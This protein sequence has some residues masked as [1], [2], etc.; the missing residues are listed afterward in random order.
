M[1][2]GGQIVPAGTVDGNV[3]VNGMSFSKRDSRFA[4]AAV[5]VNVDPDD[6]LLKPW[7]EKHG[8]MGGVK[9]Q[10]DMER[11]AAEMGG[12]NFTVPV[13]RMT[14][15]VSRTCPS[16]SVPPPRSS[17][18][19]GVKECRLDTLYPPQITAALTDAFQNIF[20]SRMP[21]FLSSSG[22]LHGVET[23]TS[24]PIRVPRDPKTM[25]SSL[26]GLFVAGEGAG[27][28]GGIVSAAV[29]GWRVGSI[30]E[31]VLFEGEGA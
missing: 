22:V 23:R 26:P 16:P 19:L 6:E 28:A 30:C 25:E 14:D 2:P 18:R 20:P 15:F 24:S 29:D 5:V 1:C 4:N 10:E 3:V 27:Y 11:R 17:Y 9:F 31:E 12:G 21:G 8:V 13:Q 7:V